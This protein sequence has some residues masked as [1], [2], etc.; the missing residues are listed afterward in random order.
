[1]QIEKNKQD[2]GGSKRDLEPQHM[3]S[4]REKERRA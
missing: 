1:M 3:R 2:T 4:D